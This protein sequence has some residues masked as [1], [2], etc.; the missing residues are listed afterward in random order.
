M[1]H[2][3]RCTFDCKWAAM[4][5]MDIGKPCY[6]FRHITEIIFV[7]FLLSSETTRNRLSDDNSLCYV[8]FFR[9][10]FAGPTTLYVLLHISRY[11]GSAYRK[12]EM[13]VWRIACTVVCAKYAYKWHRTFRY[14]ALVE[15]SHGA[16]H[17]IH[18]AMRCRKRNAV[19]HLCW[20]RT[21]ADAREQ[22]IIVWEREYGRTGAPLSC[23]YC[24]LPACT[25]NSKQEATIVELRII[26]RANT[27]RIGQ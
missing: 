4:L 26:H 19:Y 22:N 9:L 20:R 18:T 8:G 5:W 6:M 3:M 23:C 2:V 11:G 27:V 12:E 13:T 1:Q 24:C 16:E 21:A 25:Q 10:L 15:L 7:S 17:S 14:T